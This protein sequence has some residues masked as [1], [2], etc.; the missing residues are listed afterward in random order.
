ML[1]GHARKFPTIDKRGKVANGF[2]QYSIIG[3][4]YR[5]ASA[6]V[7][8]AASA[9]GG[10]A[11]S[12]NPMLASRTGALCPFALSNWALSRLIH[13]IGIQ[14]CLLHRVDS[15]PSRGIRMRD[16]AMR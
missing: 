4:P 14:L 16:S 12:G 2:A 6:H 5:S 9:V 13:G 1:C 8:K 15:R 11:K 3:K 10:K 7:A